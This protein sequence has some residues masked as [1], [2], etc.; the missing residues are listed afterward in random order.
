MTKWGEF[1]NI[2]KG[3][4][5]LSRI[6]SANIFAGIISAIFWF[7]IAGLLGTEDYGQISYFFAIANIAFTICYL[8]AG[9]SVIVYTA[10]ENKKQSI[11]KK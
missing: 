11:N 2:G 8:G 5:G 1:K 10:K 7:L 4:R 9:H 6:A 3:L